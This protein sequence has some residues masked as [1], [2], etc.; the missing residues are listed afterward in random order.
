MAEATD[1]HLQFGGSF[2]SA[3]P[4][5]LFL[6]SIFFLTFTARVIVSP[7]MPMIEKESGISHSA[8]GS[9]F[10]IIILGYVISILFSPNLSSRI[11]NR[12]TIVLSGL[13]TGLGL[14]LFSLCH[15][16]PAFLA[17]S[18]FTGLASG[19]YLPAAMV[20]IAE[21]SPAAWLTRGMSIHELAPN[22][23]FVL[24]PLITSLFGILTGWRLGLQALGVLIILWNLVYLKRGCNAKRK[25]PPVSLQVVRYFFTSPLFWRITIML[26]FAS[27]ATMGIYSMLPLLLVNE[28]GMSVD[29]A[30][31]LV[32]ISRIASIIMPLVGGWLGDRFGNGRVMAGVL[33]LAGLL[34]VPLG[35]CSGGVLLVFI[36]VQ[37]LISVS[38]FP[39][40]FARYARLGEGRF[41]GMGI[42]LGTPIGFLMGAGCMPVLI[43][44]VGDYAG[45]KAGFTVAGVLIIMAA[46]LAGSSRTFLQREEK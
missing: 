45:L 38:F 22:F 34:T 35:I 33:L 43:G 21:L 10:F 46:L 36:F 13:L 9:L 4:S 27:S 32:A 16:L 25:Q 14:F 1:S 17:A 39:S 11:G 2:R 8:E 40:C 37:P 20:T 26:S 12:H 30:N 31:S 42:S 19:L 23:G 24:A 7:L 15:S 5:L 41:R 18:L 6:S 3:L 28:H 44:T 29:R